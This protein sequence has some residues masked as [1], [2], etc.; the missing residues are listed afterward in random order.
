M[1]DHKE[2]IFVNGFP[3]S[4][5]TWL[6]RLLAECLAS[7]SGSGYFRDEID[8]ATE[9]HER[10]GE[11]KVLKSHYFLDDFPKEHLDKRIVCPVRDVRDVLVSAFFFEYMALQ[12]APR[13]IRYL[14]RRFDML[15]FFYDIY[16]MDEKHVELGDSG[17]IILHVK[18]YW[19][20]KKFVEYIRNTSKDWEYKSAATNPK[21]E[22]SNWLKFYRQWSSFDGKIV[23]VRYEDLLLDTLT[24][25]KRIL[26]ELQIPLPPENE[27]E[28]AVVKQSFE[29]KRRY[30]T[31][32]KK[33]STFRGGKYN[34]N[35]LRTGKEGEWRNYLPPA[36]EE[37][38]V[39]DH[40]QMMERF[41]YLKEIRRAIP[42]VK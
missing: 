39:N 38:I 9:G 31:E 27:L 10:K 26:Q 18:K 11:Y 8:I 34:F 6:T 5:N 1:S 33:A 32:N 17:S 35:F 29:N 14:A 22:S 20:R 15:N 7:P 2:L 28:T 36:L 13:I 12:A 41:G 23:F 24:E 42:E 19:C 30:F 25:V 40:V 4:G 37:V 21:H 3:K 16:K